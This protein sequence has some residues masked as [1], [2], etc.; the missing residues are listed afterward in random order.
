VCG[1]DFLGQRDEAVGDGCG[2]LL[3]G[4]AES[5]PMA[6]TTCAAGMLRKDQLT[7]SAC[8]RL[9]WRIQFSLPDV[10]GALGRTRS[11][12]ERLLPQGS[13]G[14]EPG[15]S[16]DLLLARNGFDSI[17]HERI[18]ANVALATSSRTNR[19]PASVQIEDVE[20]DKLFEPGREQTH[21]S[22]ASARRPSHRERWQSVTLSERE[23]AGTRGAGW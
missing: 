18:Q 17:Q 14:E 4:S 9:D 5:C 1:N 10:P 3:P 11:L 2:K 19:I 20:A 15:D 7:L 12:L 23:A 8:E 16:L 6:T 13:Q 21:G 22:A